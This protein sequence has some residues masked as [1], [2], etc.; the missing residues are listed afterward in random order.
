MVRTTQTTN[1]ISRRTAV[2]LAG[3]VALA[4]GGVAAA[5]VPAASAVPGQEIVGAW[6]VGNAAFGSR[7]LIYHADGSIVVTQAEPRT[8]QIGAWERVGDNQFVVHTLSL[9]L[10]ATMAEIGTYEV[11]A[12]VTVSQDSNGYSGTVVQHEYVTTGILVNTVNTTIT[13]QRVMPTSTIPS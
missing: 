9:K 1:S 12:M 4:I 3:G 5:G 2:R 10:D 8:P 6:R 13:G 11:D 7:L